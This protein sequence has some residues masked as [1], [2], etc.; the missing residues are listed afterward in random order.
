MLQVRNATPFQAD[1]ALFP[2]ERGVDTVYPILKGTFDVADT[3]DLAAQQRPLNKTDVYRGDPLTTGLAA[4]GEYH[5]SKPGTEVL[6][7]GDCFLAD[8]ADFQQCGVSLMAGNLS[9]N[10]VV[11]GNRYWDRGKVSSAEALSRVPLIYEHAFGGRYRDDQ[12]LYDPNPIGVGNSEGLQVHELDGL[13]LPNIES[14]TQLISSPSCRPEPAGFEAIPPYWKKRH[15]FAGTYDDQ[16]RR[17]RAPFLPRDYDSQFLL[18]SGSD[19]HQQEPFEGGEP[20][21]I[22]NMHEQGDWE[23]CLPLIEVECH[24]RWQNQITDVPLQL[25]TISL[26]PNESQ[27]V[28]TWRGAV[29]V[30]QWVTRFEYAE[31]FLKSLK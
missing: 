6:V 13:P 24:A 1:L 28:C 17:E 5:L 14:P 10:L 9:K 11:F 18:C 25:E 21:V 30:N 8:G 7:F 29:P 20:I 4:L 2:N 23:F 27:F 31:F 12:P 15:K 16:W 3:I 19:L 22:S 26:Y